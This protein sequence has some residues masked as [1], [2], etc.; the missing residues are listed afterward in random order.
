[1]RKTTFNIAG[2]LLASLAM[3]APGRAWGEEMQRQ[4]RSAHHLGMGDAGLSSVMGADAI[5]YNPAGL[6]QGKGILS[7][8]ILASPQVTAG[9]NSTKLY[10]DIQD[11]KEVLDLLSKYQGEPLHLGVQNFTGLAFRRSAFGVLAQGQTS[12]FSGPDPVSGL[13]V[14]QVGAVAR[15]GVT[16]SL[17]KGFFD[18]SLFLGTTLKVLHKREFELKMSVLEAE[19]SLKGKDFSAVM[20]EAMKAGIGAGADFGLI[21]KAQDASVKPALGVVVRN[22][23]MSYTLDGTPPE[24]APS[25]DPMMVDVGVS[26]EP[27]TKRSFSRLSI[28]LRDVADAQREIIYKRLHVGGELSFQGVLGV[29]GG[30]NQGYPT[31]GAFLALKVLRIEGGSYSEELGKKPGDLRSRRYYARVSVGWTQ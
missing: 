2:G 17:A 7:E 18:E 29:M 19:R 4:Y 26:I 20:D 14:A 10:K 23:G 1:M 5:F 9:A 11:K 24:D 30:V 12:L 8:A 21:W 31:Y 13:P 25:E 27:Q 15:G 16:L 22:V 6:A 3:L 28:D